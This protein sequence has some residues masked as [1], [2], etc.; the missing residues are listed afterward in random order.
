MGERSEMTPFFD[1]DFACV[2]EK[3]VDRR[4]TFPL[5]GDHITFAPS[6]LISIH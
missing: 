5:C 1:S 3:L 4:M 2:H 6:S